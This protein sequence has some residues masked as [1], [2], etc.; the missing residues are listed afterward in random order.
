MKTYQY[1]LKLKPYKRGFH[2]ITDEVM[3]ACPDLKDVNIGM[4]NLFLRHTSASLSI[5][6]N[7]DPSVR[8][9]FE[10]FSSDTFDNKPYFQHTLEG[11]DDMPAHLKSSMYGVSLNIPITSGELNLGTWQGIYLGEHRDCAT[12][13]TIIIT[14]MGV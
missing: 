12:S 7:Y 1:I 8:A 5:N 3:D 4:M 2:L 9:D 14:L 10:S 13:R 11:A 6:E